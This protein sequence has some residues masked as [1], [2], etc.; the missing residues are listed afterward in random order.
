MPKIPVDVFVL[1][2]LLTDVHS[3]AA[4]GCVSCGAWFLH[5]FAPPGND[6]VAFAPCQVVVS[7]LI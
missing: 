1:K 6:C 3:Y 2:D 4:F 5:A 7:F